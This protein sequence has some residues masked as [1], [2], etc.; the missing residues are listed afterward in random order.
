[1][2]AKQGTRDPFPNGHV[3]FLYNTHSSRSR[4]FL[5]RP[6]PG[7]YQAG[8]RA[9]AGSVLKRERDGSDEAMMTEDAGEIR[10]IPR[11]EASEPAQA[12][13]DTRRRLDQAQEGECIVFVSHLLFTLVPQ[14]I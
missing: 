6:L 8:H 5:A 4:F 11:P 12:S 3:L 14:C 1:M 2:L 7:K 13:N 10:K 9:T